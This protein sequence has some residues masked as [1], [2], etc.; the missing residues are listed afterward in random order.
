[1]LK[2]LII[3]YVW[4]EPD[5]SAAGSRMLQLIQLFLQQHWQLTYASPAAD[6]EHM[7]DIQALGVEK[8]GIK[9]NSSCFDSFVRQLE[10]DIVLFDRFMM[11]EQFG[12][13]VEKNCPQALRLLDSEDLHCLR[14]ARHR[15]V[16]Q[17]RALTQSDLSGDLALREVASIL[18]SDLTLMISEF[19]IE[20]LLKH[21]QVSPALLHH[22]RFMLPGIDPAVADGW[23]SFSQ[24]QHFI[25]IGNFRHA[26]N[27]D[28]VLYLHRQ[29]WPLI[30]QQL[31]EAE[32]HIYGAYPPPRAT[33]LDNNKQGFRL[34]GWA[35]DALAVMGSA[36]VCLAPLRFGA[37]IKGKLTLAMQAGTP[38][39]TTGIGAE[40]MHDELPW[41]GIIED[42]PLRF[43]AEAVRLYQDQALWQQSQ[44]RG[45][46]IINQCYDQQAIGDSLIQRID[47]LR[48]QLEQHRLDNFTGAMLRHHRLK[49]C[50][51]M[52]QWI[53][54]KNSN[55]DSGHKDS[56][57][58]DSSHKDKQH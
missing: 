39:V 29:I 1:M 49:S 52:S 48:L 11:E 47:Q 46:Q 20:L 18:R 33:Q 9:L 42:D 43:A 41:S 7:A 53:E 56:S 51:Y 31:P 30:R 14:D 25:S 19:E 38:S 45:R 21:F 23:P 54:A 34:L 10:P 22:S 2:L 17:Q 5:S 24:R 28:A 50:Q 6:S 37:G 40:G 36:R 55:R 44:V 16:K 27:W 32:L 57:Y 15:A 13:R 3:G 8:V 4:P 26:P 35:K 12:W 58:K